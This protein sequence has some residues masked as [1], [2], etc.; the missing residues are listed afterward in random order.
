MCVH[1]WNINHMSNYNIYFDPKIWNR[2]AVKFVDPPK[3][4]NFS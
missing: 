4:I 2:K 3:S 1:K